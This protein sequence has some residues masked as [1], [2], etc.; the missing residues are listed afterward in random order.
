MDRDRRR[1]RQLDRPAGPRA[2]RWKAW[3]DGYGTTHT[4]TL[5][6]SVSIPAGCGAT[7]S[8]YLHIDTAETTTIDRRT[9][10]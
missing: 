3:L 4:D 7:L 8:F 1:H 2:V 9:T 6:Q 5:C 10:S